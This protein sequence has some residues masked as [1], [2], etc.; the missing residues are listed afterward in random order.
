MT[1]EPMQPTT[2]PT[3]RMARGMWHLVDH[4][5]TPYAGQMALAYR[6]VDVSSLDAMRQSCSRPPS[7][8]SLVVKALA[9]T[10]AQHPEINRAILGPPGWRRLM[11]FHSS[12]IAVALEVLTPGDGVESHAHFEII[13]QAANCSAS[14]ISADLARAAQA[15]RQQTD[16]RWR[17]LRHLLTLPRWLMRGILHQPF[18]HAHLWVEHRGSACFVNSPAQHGADLIITH[19]PWPLTITFGLVEPRALVVEGQVCA[20]PTLPLGISFDRRILGGGPAVRALSTLAGVLTR[21]DPGPLGLNTASGATREPASGPVA[22][23]GSPS[24]GTLP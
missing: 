6:M 19:W 13:R 2:V 20:R 24:S 11:Q 21:A 10:L 14:Q 5:I 7:W 23:G 9:A 22:P 8:T 4:M 18:W 3:S 15:H 1:P 12:D 16:P 17:G